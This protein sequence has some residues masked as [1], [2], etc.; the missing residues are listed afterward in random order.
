V[1]QK[2]AEAAAQHGVLRTKITAVVLKP[3]GGEAL[4]LWGFM[5]AGGVG[6]ED[7]GCLAK[8]T[9]NAESHLIPIDPRSGPRT[10]PAEHPEALQSRLGW[11]WPHT[12]NP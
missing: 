11:A 7:E 3:V 10:R 4:G 2:A 5:R 6:W 8:P 12:L 9:L 1:A